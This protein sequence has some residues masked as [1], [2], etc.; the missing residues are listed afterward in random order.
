M[1][2]LLP[3]VVAAQNFTTPYPTDSI[4]VAHKWVR[5][6]VWRNGFTAA[7]PARQVNEVEF[8]RQYRRNKEQWDKLFHWLSTTDLLA[9]PAG[10]HP[11]EGTSLVASVEDSENQPLEKRRSESHYRHIDFQYVVRGTE[12]FR[13]IDHNTS[14]PNCPYDAKKD[15]VHY[16]YSLAKTIES[17]KGTFNIFFPCDWHIAK[18]ATR[19]KDQKIRVIVVKVDYK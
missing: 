12:G 2:L 8:M 9:L 14:R 5:S 11:I 3:L 10:K 16:D 7:S 1:M 15:V 4:Q 19:K 13:L 6:G 18:V 17:R